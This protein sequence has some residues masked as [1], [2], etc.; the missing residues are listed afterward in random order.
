MP[1]VLVT[2]VGVGANSVPDESVI[3]GSK[4]SACS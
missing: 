3:D 4:W 2:P 1:V